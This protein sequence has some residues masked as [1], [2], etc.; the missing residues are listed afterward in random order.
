MVTVK[1]QSGSGVKL[2][3]GSAEGAGA[4]TTKTGGD[5]GCGY[6][7]ICTHYGVGVGEW[8]GYGPHR[9]FPKK[10]NEGETEL[11]SA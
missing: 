11:T 4:N 3:C 9:R 5:I 8:T 7:G 2:H 10:D 6:R 1:R